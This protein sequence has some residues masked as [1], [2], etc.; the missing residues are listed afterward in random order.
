MFH[1]NYL[2]ELEQRF[3]RYVRIDTQSTENVPDF[4]STPGQWELLRLLADELRGMGAHDVTLTQWGYVL[5][6]IPA[7]VPTSDLPTVALLAHVDTAPDYPG[8]NVRP[9]IHRNYRGGPIVLPDDPRQVLNW[10]NAPELRDK[11]GEDIITA[12]GTTLL[13]ADDK[14]GVAI[15][16]TLAARLL[17]DPH[18]PHPPLR[19]C[20]TPDEEIGRGVDHLSLAELAANV[21]YTLDGEGAGEIV[22]ENFCA[23]RAIVTITGVAIHPGNA[24]GRMVNA[25]RLATR[26]A[27]MLPRDH[28]TPETT[29]GREGYIHLHDIR[30]NVAQVQMRILLRDFEEEGLRARAQLVRSLCEQLQ[31]I[32]PRARIECVIERQYRNMRYW[33]EKDMRPVHLAEEAIRRAGLQ[34]V[35]VPT[36]GGT[37]GARLTE[38]GL[39]TPNLFVGTHNPHGPTEWISLQDMARSLETCLHLVQ[40]WAE[41]GHGYTGWRGA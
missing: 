6:T 41:H 18:I 7:T 5:A 20:F 37:D 14:A 28:D 27:E 25:I 23:D 16:M 38:C 36:R 19:L 11:I 9:M 31:R 12:S 39:P 3:I 10:E 34:P 21:A 30:G 29:E 15:L 8:A 17:A 1:P 26:L 13:G 33:L 2:T 22:Y 35:S 32:E 4:P 40:L 24:K